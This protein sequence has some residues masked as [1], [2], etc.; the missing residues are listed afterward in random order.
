MGL[1]GGG[2]YRYDGHEFQ[3]FKTERRRPRWDHLC[4]AGDSERLVD[5]LKRWRTRPN[6]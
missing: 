4:A 2:L 5:W 1:W 6:S 3:R